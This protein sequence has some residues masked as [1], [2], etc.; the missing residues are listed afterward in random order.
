M[1]KLARFENKF[2]H[3]KIEE[4]KLQ[5]GNSKQKWL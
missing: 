5:E 2:E 3:G 4:E 1:R